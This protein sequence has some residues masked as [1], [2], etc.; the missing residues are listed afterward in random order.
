MLKKLLLICLFALPAAAQE[1]S[2]GRYGS[3]T[4]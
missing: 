2:R 1:F 4:V 3:C